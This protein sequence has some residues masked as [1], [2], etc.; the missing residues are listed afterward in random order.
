MVLED[1][2]IAV[3]DFD[4]E[5]EEGAIEETNFQEEIDETDFEEEELDDMFHSVD[6]L[7]SLSDGS[8]N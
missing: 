1:V 6:W 3:L 5:F 2:V 7:D 4:E 8:L